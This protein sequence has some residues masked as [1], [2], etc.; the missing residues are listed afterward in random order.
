MKKEE[1]IQ[2]V[3]ELTEKKLNLLNELK[4]S[5][6][7]EEKIYDLLKF[8]LGYEFSYILYRISD[9]I[10][11]FDGRIKDLKTYIKIRNI[12]IETIYNNKYLLPKIEKNN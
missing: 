11:V 10:E 8:N 2:Q 5:V 12:D 1:K 3:I 9:K 7:Y 4:E 6:I